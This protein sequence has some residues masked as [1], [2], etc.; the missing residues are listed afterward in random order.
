MQAGGE[1]ATYS[2]EMITLAQA[3]SITATDELSFATGSARDMTA[4]FVPGA[5]DTVVLV[6]DGRSVTFGAPITSVSGAGHISFADG[7]RLYLGTPAAD[8]PAAGGLQNDAFFGGEGADT[9]NGGGGANLLQGNTGA[10]QLAGGAGA[11]TIYG[12]QDNDLIVTGDGVN[13]GQGNKGNDSI[14][15]GLGADTLLGGQGDDTISSGAVSFQ[16]DGANFLNGNL[17]DDFIRAGNGNDQIFGEAGNDTLDAGYGDSFVD[18]GDGQDSIEA[19]LGFNT[20]F[21]GTGDDTISSQSARISQLDGGAGDDQIYGAGM[22]AG[23]D[24]D[25][26]LNGSAGDGQF[27]GATLDGGLGND[28]IGA[29]NENDS[30]SGGDGDDT[31]YGASGFDTLTGGQGID[32]FQFRSGDASLFAAAPTRHDVISD[33][34]GQD[35]LTFASGGSPD[36]LTRAVAGAASNYVELS[37]ADFASAQTAAAGQEVAGKLYVAVQV[38]QDV[39]VFA[40]MLGFSPTGSEGVF[41][42]GRSLND[43]DFTNI[44]GAS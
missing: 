11:D 15:G 9:L 24:G 40:N 31:L 28:V 1:M 38:G 17:G 19:Q 5:P 44:V 3:L 43:I 36:S 23:G 37:A 33:W 32:L 30:L 18:G 2:F 41:L 34:S 26:T 13:F 39:I 10:D 4:L 22:L 7:S 35:C 8:S 6:L 20:I 21:G 16:P 42:V 14:A 25:D 27:T 29:G 12:G